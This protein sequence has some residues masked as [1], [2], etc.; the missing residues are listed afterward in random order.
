MEGKTRVPEL[1]QEQSANSH[2][3]LSKC[4]GIK[5][6]EEGIEGQ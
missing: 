2:E 4:N 1:L 6:P 5:K 3:F